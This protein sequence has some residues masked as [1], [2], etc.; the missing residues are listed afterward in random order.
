MGAGAGDLD[1][2]VAAVTARFEEGATY[3][4]GKRIR[5]VLKTFDDGQRAVAYLE[6]GDTLKAFVIA[7]PEYWE[8]RPAGLPDICMIPA[9]GCIGEAH[10]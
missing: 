4:K 1:S 3:A 8:K 7:K 9:C 2:G 6:Q 10:A 5:T